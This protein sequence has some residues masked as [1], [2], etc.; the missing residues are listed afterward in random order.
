MGVSIENRRF[1]HRADYL[2]LVSAAAIQHAYL[3]AWL[4][5]LGTSFSPLVLFDGFAGAG[6]RPRAPAPRRREGW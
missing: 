1:A 4:A 3:G 2:R 5:I 6:T